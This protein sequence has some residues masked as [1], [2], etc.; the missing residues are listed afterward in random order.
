[1]VSRISVTSLNPELKT[2]NTS[3]GPLQTGINDVWWNRG[4]YCHTQPRLGNGANAAHVAKKDNPVLFNLP[5][6]FDDSF[7]KHGFSVLTKKATWLQLS[8]LGTSLFVGK[9]TQMSWTDLI[10]MMNMSV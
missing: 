7:L 3:Q 4:H 8:G 9:K 5:F 2:P 1:M 10:E 6:K